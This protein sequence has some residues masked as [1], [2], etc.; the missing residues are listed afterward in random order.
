MRV[1]IRGG[2][3]ERHVGLE[4]N[5]RG[6]RNGE[7]EV[8]LGERTQTDARGTRIGVGHEV[9]RGDEQMIAAGDAHLPGVF[10][11]AGREHDEAQR[12]LPSE[13]TKSIEESGAGLDAR[14]VDD[15]GIGDSF[16]LEAFTVRT[17]AASKANSGAI[18]GRASK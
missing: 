9:L 3:D 18:P 4:R 2:G 16:P 1:S 14:D 11:F 5:S 7:L 10:C 15:A 8:R 17:V 13:E 12:S 6:W